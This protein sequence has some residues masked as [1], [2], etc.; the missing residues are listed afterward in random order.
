MLR[1]RGLKPAAQAS[2][3]SAGEL[4]PSYGRENIY[5]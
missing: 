1:E 3:Y 4:S 2:K 5:R